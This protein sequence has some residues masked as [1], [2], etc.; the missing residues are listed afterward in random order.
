V[1]CNSA[2]ASEIVAGALQDHDRGL[3]VGSNT[4]GKGL[5]Q[6]VYNLSDTT[7]LVLT[8]A[9]YYTP[10][11]RM[12]QRPYDH[13]SPRKYYTDPC[14]DSYRPPREDPRVTDLG[15]RVFGGGGITP[16]VHIDQMTRSKFQRLMED[17]RTF[18]GHAQQYCLERESLPEGWAPGEEDT[19]AFRAYLDDRLILFDDDA[20]SEEGAYI[21]RQI[22]KHIYTA[23]VNYDEGLRVEIELDPAVHEAVA[24]LPEARKLLD[25]VTEALAQRD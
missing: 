1:N 14:A 15:R 4:F 13:I 10:S 2:S 20:F 21:E 11:G 19:E 22:K 5:V 18:E 24:L 3:I 12:I 8:T 9:R 17:R 7:G 25:R 6:A 16:D 23:C